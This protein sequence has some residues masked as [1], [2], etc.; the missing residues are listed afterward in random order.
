MTGFLSGNKR[1][2]NT[3]LKFCQQGQRAGRI[4][5]VLGL[6]CL[7][8]SVSSFQAGMAAQ[9]QKSDSKQESTETI[10]ARLQGL[11]ILL[12][13]WRGITQRQYSGAKAVDQTGW[14]WDFQ[15]DPEFPALVMDSDKSPHYR[16]A[17]L[18]YLPEKKV[19]QLT[20]KNEAGE[21]S[22]LQGAFTEEIANEPGEDG[23]AQRTYKLE[24]TEVGGKEN[25]SARFVFNQQNNNRYLLEIYRQRGS[26][27]RFVRVDTVSTQ[28]EGTSFASSDEDYGEKT[29]IIS[30]GLGTIAVSHAGATYY[31]CCTGCKAA[32]EEDPEKW[33]AR[34]KEQ[35]KK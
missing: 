30:A 16:N 29:C 13:T 21:T 7:V 28:R 1:L 24:L 3:G 35:K 11:Q 32:F 9:K 34:S 2:L 25:E 12:G 27:G 19:Y 10:I 6:V 14:V 18:T 8:G 15:T 31:V 17:I 5:L 26:S 20:L 22:V 4:V 33:I 23:K